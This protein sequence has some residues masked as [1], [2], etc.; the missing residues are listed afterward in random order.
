MKKRGFEIVTGYEDR[1]I[2]LPMRKTARSAGYDL[3]AAEDCVIEPGKVTMI[4]TGVKAYMQADE[5]LGLHI[6][7]GFSLKNKLSFINSEGII[8]SEYYNN[9][10]NEGHIF[11]AIMNYGES[12]VY[13]KKGMR[14]AQGV[15]YKYLPADGDIPG[16]GAVRTGGFG[17]TGTV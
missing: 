12:P 3:E 2:H 14:I 10:E 4:P 5:Y 11:A 17:S 13:V 8:D 16:E 15:F 9:P 1:G 6:R 7:S